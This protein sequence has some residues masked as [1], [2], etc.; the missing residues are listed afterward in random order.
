MGS[1]L[2]NDSPK[3][4]GSW[5]P[6]PTGRHAERYF[7][8]GQPTKL[9]RDG[10]LGSYSEGYDDIGSPSPHAVAPDS[11]ETLSRSES[12]LHACTEPLTDPAG[13]PREGGDSPQGFLETHGSIPD[14]ATG[15]VSMTMELADA[16]SSVSPDSMISTLTEVAA[17][18]AIG[19][20]V[21]PVAIE[22]L[23]ISFL[24]PG[25]IGPVIATATPVHIDKHDG[26]VEVKVVDRGMDDRLMA[27]AT[28]TVR[29]LSQ[30]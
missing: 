17:M 30:N 26:V 6:D 20:T 7:S 1:F 4:K 15:S 8:L 5:R 19:R 12:D 28:V 11:A 13:D 21:G 14:R 29:V 22:H 23:D 16:P 3:I 2:E 18:S 27:V 25:R 10:E 24:E 9:Y